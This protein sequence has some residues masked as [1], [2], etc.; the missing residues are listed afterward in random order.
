[1]PVRSATLDVARQQMVGH[2][3]EDRGR[4]LC[5]RRVVEEHET[6][7]P[8]QR[9]ESPAHI[10]DGKAIRHGPQRACARTQWTP[11]PETAERTRR[12][13]AGRPRKTWWPKS[14]PARGVRTTQPR[15]GRAS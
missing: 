12:C 3:L 1:M 9:R 4:N 8:L 11:E 13:I 7:G 5:A 15:D 14:P 2:R 10:V 6:P